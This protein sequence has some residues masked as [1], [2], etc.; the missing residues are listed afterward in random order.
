M[1]D[2]GERDGVAIHLQAADQTNRQSKHG[3][4]NFFATSLSLELKASR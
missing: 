4:V 2:G 3:A 1:F